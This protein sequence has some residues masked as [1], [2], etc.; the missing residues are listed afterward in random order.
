MPYARKRGNQIVIAHGFRDPETRKVNQ[1]ILFTIYSKAEA[2]RILGQKS[3]GAAHHFQA[4]LEGQHPGLKFDWPKI[5]AFVRSQ[6]DVLPD[7][8]PYKTERV[9]KDFRKEM[10]DFARQLILAD[11][12]DLQ[13]AAQLIRENRRE[14]T[15]LADLIRF[16][17][18]HVDQPANA[19][20]PDDPFFW[21]MRLQGHGV[22]P[23]TEEWVADLY[24]QGRHE[25]AAAV[26]GLLIEAFPEYAEG[27]NYLGL[28][29]LARG[30]LGKALAFFEQTMATGEKL[31]P[32]GLAR[33]HYWD[34]LD[35]RPFMRGLQNAILVLNR[36]QRYDDALSLCRRLDKQ[37]GDDITAELWRATVHL[38]M[39]AWQQAAEEAVHVCSLYKNESF[40]AAFAFFEVGDREESLTYFIHGTMN[41]PE[42]ASMLVDGRKAKRH[43][44]KISH[45]YDRFLSMTA[46]LAPYLRRQRRDAKAFFKAA[47]HHPVIQ[48]HV[49]EIDPSQGGQGDERT[50]AAR[51]R[52]AMRSL[53]FARQEARRIIEDL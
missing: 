48:A 41:H 36:L 18:D 1:Q 4:L 19:S 38:N 30:D 26:F 44:K 17:L 14:L 43:P 50:Q 47:C 25:D 7:L 22:P 39:G 40:T 6:M 27:Y 46:N 32:R 29:A 51:R 35:T 49:A 10:A 9:Q 21:R 28:I 45:D 31:F 52:E 53:G 15:F 23:S 24:D 3:T 34:D 37:C 42:M 11:P 13:S 8:Y 5:Q 33:K 2:L 16:H 20:N 12:Q